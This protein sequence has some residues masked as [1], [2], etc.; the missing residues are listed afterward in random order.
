[1]RIRSTTVFE[2]WIVVAGGRKRRRKNGRASRYCFVFDTFKKKWIQSNVLLK[3]SRNSHGSIFSVGAGAGAGGSQLVSIGEVNLNSVLMMER[4]CLI[5]NWN[6]I[7]YFVLLR[8][9]VDDR[10][11]IVVHNNDESLDSDDNIVVVKLMTY[12]NMDTFR[13]TVFFLI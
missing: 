2:R 9:L 12:L 10:R 6:I 7:E 4:Q 8:R 11:E 13:H 5:S 3:T 1:M